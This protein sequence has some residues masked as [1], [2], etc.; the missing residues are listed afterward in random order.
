MDQNTKDIALKMLENFNTLAEDLKG[1]PLSPLPTDEIIPH[2]GLEVCLTGEDWIPT[3]GTLWRSWTG[4][5]RIWGLEY[6][7]PVFNI[8]RPDGTPFAGKRSCGCSVCQ[9]HV[10]SKF[11]P[12]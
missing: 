1:V 8:D 2:E 4:R 9:E 5:R 3:T 7:G 6:H 10:E 11:R 12:N